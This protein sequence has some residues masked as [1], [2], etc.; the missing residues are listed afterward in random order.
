MTHQLKKSKGPRDADAGTWQIGPPADDG[1]D[2]TIWT[3][4]VCSKNHALDPATHTVDSG[5]NIIG[6]DGKPVAVECTRKT[7]DFKDELQLA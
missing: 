7:C 5:G 6:P 1:P 2:R 3:C 4:P